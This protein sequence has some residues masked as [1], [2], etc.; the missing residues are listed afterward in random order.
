MDDRLHYTALYCP[1][2][3][4]ETSLDSGHAGQWTRY[5]DLVYLTYD[6]VTVDCGGTAGQVHPHVT[7]PRIL[8][9]CQ[10]YHKQGVVAPIVLA[11][12]Q[13]VGNY[14]NFQSSAP[15]RL[16]SNISTILGVH[17]NTFIEV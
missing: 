16:A 17:C 15:A 7:V 5:M 3:T 10:L 13:P 12:W 14:Q 6:V 1:A 11:C 8:T 9:R 2:L 4:L